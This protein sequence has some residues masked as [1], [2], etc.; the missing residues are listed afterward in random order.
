[1]P[2]AA[3]E[4]EPDAESAAGV[5]RDLGFSARLVERSDE[6]YDDRMRAFFSGRER[7]FEVHA[8]LVSDAGIDTFEREVASHHG[9][10]IDDDRGNDL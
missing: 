6:S 1:M 2:K 8:V 5:L 10:V 3:F 7:P 4:H 9:H